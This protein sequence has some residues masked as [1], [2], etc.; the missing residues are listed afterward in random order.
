MSKSISLMRLSHKLS[1]LLVLPTFGGA[2]VE[3]SEPDVTLGEGGGITLGDR[4]IDFATI[5]AGDTD[6]LLDKA[7]DALQPGG[8]ISKGL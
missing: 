3:Y 7:G 2:V 5:R 8:A 4:G 1:R 6:D